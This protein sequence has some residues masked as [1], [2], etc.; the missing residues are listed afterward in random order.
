MKPDSLTAWTTASHYFS[1]LKS[2]IIIYVNI[3]VAYILNKY[4]ISKKSEMCLCLTLKHLN[5][6]NITSWCAAVD[7]VFR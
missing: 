4:S 5:S 1:L 2:V 7:K 6:K 3:C